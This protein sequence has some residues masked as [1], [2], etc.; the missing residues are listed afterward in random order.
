M[1]HDQADW[2]FHKKDVRKVSFSRLFFSFSTYSAA[3]VV[4]IK[5]D[6]H[7]DGGVYFIHYHWEEDGPF[8]VLRLPQYTGTMFAFRNLATHLP[9]ASSE[10]KE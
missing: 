5:K 4:Y 3:A 9:V 10:W 7:M 6:V 1:I 8:Y 2:T